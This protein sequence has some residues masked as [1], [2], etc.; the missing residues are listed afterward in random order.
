LI[1]KF[2]KVMVENKTTINYF[3]IIELPSQPTQ[4]F[5]IPDLNKDSIYYSS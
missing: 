4:N 1:I 5:F 3:Q 2:K